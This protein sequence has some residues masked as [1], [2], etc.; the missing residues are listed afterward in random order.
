MF[1]IERKSTLDQNISKLYGVVLGHCTPDLKEDGIG[2]DDYGVYF[3]DCY[4]LWLF[5]HI[6]LST[7]SAERYQYEH[8][9]YVISLSFFNGNSSARQKST[10]G[11][12]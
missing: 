1:F 8:L 5:Q 10:E 7:S 2:L 12:S 3:K 4:F 9:S 6:N 11:I